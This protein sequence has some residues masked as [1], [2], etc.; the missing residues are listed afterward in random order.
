MPELSGTFGTANITGRV[1]APF[2]IVMVPA[3]G[4]LELGLL[5]AA[6]IPVLL[7]GN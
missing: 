2:L 7:N 4:D 5:V 3:V 1:R 6:A